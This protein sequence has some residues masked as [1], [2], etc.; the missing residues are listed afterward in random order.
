MHVW[1]NSCAS[2]GGTG[3]GLVERAIR[4]RIPPLVSSLRAYV[5][6]WGDV[7]PDGTAGR[8]WLD[9]VPASTLMPSG[10]WR[11]E[12]FGHNWPRPAA[13]LDG[14]WLS[15]NNSPL[16]DEE[17][18]DLGFWRDPSTTDWVREASADVAHSVVEQIVQRQFFVPQARGVNR[19]I[20]NG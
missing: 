4:L 10:P 15:I 9:L 20:S 8:L 14:G 3:A 16:P 11:F 13:R 12:R 7:A 6:G 19:V 1:P 5:D 17:M 2:C 18:R